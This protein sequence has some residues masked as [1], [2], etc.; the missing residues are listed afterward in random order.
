MT[1]SSR[2]RL[3]LPQRFEQA[4]RT[5]R[6]AQGRGVRFDPLTEVPRDV[7]NREQSFLRHVKAVVLL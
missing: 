7:R 1:A 5:L 4:L 2:F 6:H 3:R